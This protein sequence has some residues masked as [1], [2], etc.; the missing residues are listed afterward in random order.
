MRTTTAGRTTATAA[1]S[2]AAL[3]ELALRPVTAGRGRSAL[4]LTV[5]LVFGAAMVA[6]SALIHLH[7]WLA[8][9]RHIA[10][11]GPAFL[12]QSLSGF[13][14]AAGMLVYRRLAAVVAGL[15]FCAGSAVALLLSATVGFLGLH[16]TLSVPWAGWSM[17]SELAGLVVLAGCATAALLARR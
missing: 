4:L 10:N 17:V 1:T 11:I 8:G 15:L 6:A 3:A 9:Y 7:L 5:C 2:K 12:L 16:D 13:A 14:L